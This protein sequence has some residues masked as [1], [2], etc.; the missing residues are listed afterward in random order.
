MKHAFLHISKILYLE[1]ALM[2]SNIDAKIPCATTVVINA[3]F[4]IY[5]CLGINQQQNVAVY[6]VTSLL[7]CEWRM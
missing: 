5:Y 6:I 4:I 1:Q 2:R 3:Y 7:P